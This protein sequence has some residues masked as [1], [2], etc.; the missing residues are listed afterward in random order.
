M[1]TQKINSLYLQHKY[2]LTAIYASGTGLSST[3]E[4]KIGVTPL[5]PSEIYKL[6]QE[7]TQIFYIRRKCYNLTNYEK[8]IF[9]SNE[10]IEINILIRYRYGA[11]KF[12]VKIVYS[13][14]ISGSINWYNLF[15]KQFVNVHQKTIKILYLWPNSLLESYPKVINPRENVI[16][17][18]I[19]CHIIYNS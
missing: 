1:T 16:H 19:N 3:R 9:S 2:K 8:K 12:V 4:W 6:S 10:N 17:A 7:I 5:W 14:I 18:V 15:G 11:S 13:Y